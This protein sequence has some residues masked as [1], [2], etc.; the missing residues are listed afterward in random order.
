MAEYQRPRPQEGLSGMASEQTVAYQEI[1]L[2]HRP[3]IQPLST[4]LALQASL[5]IDLQQSGTI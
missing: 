1:M 5:V 2:H 3:L 4:L